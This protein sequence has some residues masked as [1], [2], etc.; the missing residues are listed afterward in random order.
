MG[1]NEPC[2]LCA[3]F[4][5]VTTESLGGFGW[6]FYWVFFPLFRLGDVL[7]LFGCFDRLDVISCVCYG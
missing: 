6:K 7:G 2:V 5:G 3:L 1:F 4:V